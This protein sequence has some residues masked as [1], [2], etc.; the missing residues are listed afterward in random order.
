[1]AYEDPPKFEPTAEQIKQACLAIQ[2]TWTRAIERS[3]RVR[4]VSMPVEVTHVRMP[5]DIR[6]PNYDEVSY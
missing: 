4:D 3:R 1:M 2:L 6:V 5:R